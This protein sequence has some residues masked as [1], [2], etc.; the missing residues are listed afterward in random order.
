MFS[1]LLEE[2]SSLFSTFISFKFRGDF[3]SFSSFRF[4]LSKLSSLFEFVV[5]LVGWVFKRNL[6]TFFEDFLFVSF[7]ESSLL[8][9]I[10][11]KK[12]LPKKNKKLKETKKPTR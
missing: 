1:F 5:E 7:S 12:K 3:S 2:D 11:M 10:K 9:A 8:K 4:L 6:P